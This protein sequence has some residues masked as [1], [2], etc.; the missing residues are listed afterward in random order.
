M[1]RVD[2]SEVPSHDEKL[3]VVQS[4]NG[5]WEVMNEKWIATNL[6]QRSFLWFDVFWDSDLKPDFPQLP[7]EARITLL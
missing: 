3:Q 6:Q 4:F 1:Y 7:E 2:V 5:Y